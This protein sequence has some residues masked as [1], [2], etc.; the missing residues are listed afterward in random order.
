[1]ARKPSNGE[2]K[3]GEAVD[4]A[5]LAR[6]VIAVNR[7]ATRLHTKLTPVRHAQAVALVYASES[8]ADDVVKL[9]ALGD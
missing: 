2:G 1:M 4:V 6:A 8:T 5:K 7:A 3:A 9:L